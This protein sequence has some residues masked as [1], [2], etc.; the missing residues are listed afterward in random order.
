MSHDIAVARSV[1]D[2][3]VV[4]YLVRIVEIRLTEQV[5]AT[6]RHPHTRSLMEAAP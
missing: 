5:F 2:R 1:C 3:V 6:L 4:L